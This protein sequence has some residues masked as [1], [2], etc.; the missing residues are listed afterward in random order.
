VLWSF[1]TIMTRHRYIDVLMSALTLLFA[2]LPYCG[3]AQKG[4]CCFDFGNAECIACHLNISLEDFCKSSPTTSGCP[5]PECCPD[6]NNAY[7]LSCLLGRHLDDVCNENPSLNGCTNH[8]TTSPSSKPTIVPTTAPTTVPTKM[9]TVIPTEQPTMVPTEPP[10]VVPTEPPTTV[11]T[12]P[13][14]VVPTTVPTTVHEHVQN[15]LTVQYEQFTTIVNDLRRQNNDL[16]SQI[17]QILGSYVTASDASSTYLTKSEAAGTYTTQSSWL[18]SLPWNSPDYVTFDSTYAYFGCRSAGCDI[19]FTLRESKS[20]EVMS[21]D[22]NT[23]GEHLD[24]SV[25]G[26][27][28]SRCRSG[29]AN[30]HSHWYNCGSYGPGTVKVDA[31][32]AVDYGDYQGYYVYLRVRRS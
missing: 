28:T 12:Q 14:I 2:V 13:P 17:D 3:P 24:I 7:C 5:T 21:T 23:S 9:P 20:V 15:E 25:D 27:S 1:Y 18:E 4:H 10:T 16:Q 29:V 30:N 26:G 6:I 32:S 22:F 19:V 11:P 31:S 8:P